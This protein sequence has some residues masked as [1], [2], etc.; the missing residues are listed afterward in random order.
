MNILS[1]NLP[2]KYKTNGVNDANFGVDSGCRVKKSTKVPD[3][4]F[5][6]AFFSGQSVLNR[7]ATIC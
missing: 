1:T 4:G 7:L 3:Q 5:L 6:C 2:D